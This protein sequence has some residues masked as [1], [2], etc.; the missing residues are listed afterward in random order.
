MMYVRAQ[1]VLPGSPSV[2]LDRLRE[3]LALR[4]AERVVAVAS[5][6]GTTHVV[7]RVWLSSILDPYTAAYDAVSEAIGAAGLAGA[8]ITIS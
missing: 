1:I 3:E 5:K 8:R 7:C 4:G 6:D 2:T